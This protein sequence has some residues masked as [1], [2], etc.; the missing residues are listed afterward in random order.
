[1]DER[2]DSQPVATPRSLSSMVER[3]SKTILMLATSRTYEWSADGPCHL[4]GC[5][6]VKGRD[7]R[8]PAAGDHERL[9]R[10][11]VVE[12]GFPQGCGVHA[13]SCRLEATRDVVE[14]VPVTGQ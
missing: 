5:A 6:A 12:F 7:A 4:P 8:L 1:M 11:L 9:R 10:R 3:V 14:R 13:E 2:P